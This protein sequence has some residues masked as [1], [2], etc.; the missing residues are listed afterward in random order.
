MTCPS[1][2]TRITSAVRMVDKRCA[3]IKLV[4]PSIRCWKASWI[5]NSVRVSMEEVASS[6]ISILG[7]PIITRAMQSNCFC[8]CEKYP[9][10]SEI[11]VSYPCGRRLTNPWIWQSLEMRIISSSLIVGFPIVILSRTVPV[12]SHVSWST[13]PNPFRR[14]WRVM[15]SIEWPSMANFPLLIS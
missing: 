11:T 13:I 10:S 4:R 2:K 8:P 9:P 5:F 3:T 15:S 7:C 12:W 14:L 1:F 6:R